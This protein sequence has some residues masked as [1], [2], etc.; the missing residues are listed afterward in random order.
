MVASNFRGL[1][2]KVRR[3]S[4]PWHP[5]CSHHRVSCDVATPVL[6]WLLEM[7]IEHWPPPNPG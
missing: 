2:T 7:L 3:A 6:L 5:P 1:P 4:A